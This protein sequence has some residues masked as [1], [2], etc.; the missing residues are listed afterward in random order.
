MEEISDDGRTTTFGP[1]AIN[2]SSSKVMKRSSEQNI[3]VGVNE[4]PER[5][6]ERIGAQSCRARHCPAPE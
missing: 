3:A 2:V 6:R 4:A 1:I 5:T